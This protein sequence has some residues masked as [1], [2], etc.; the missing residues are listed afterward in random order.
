MPKRRAESW[1]RREFLG[2]LTLTGTAG[3]L[4]LRAR[5]VAA[6]PP[7]E[8]TT[9]KLTKGIQ[10]DHEARLLSEHSHHPAGGW[11]AGTWAMP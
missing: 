6:E 11:L 9:L 4:G 8:T 1:S 5:P 3:L 7:P 10:S 2:R